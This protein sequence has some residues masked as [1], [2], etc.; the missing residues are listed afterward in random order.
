MLLACKRFEGV[1]NSV[2]EIKTDSILTR[3]TDPQLHHFST[4]G[5]FEKSEN[6]NF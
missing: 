2:R 6:N 4:N 3:I 5:E 1:F